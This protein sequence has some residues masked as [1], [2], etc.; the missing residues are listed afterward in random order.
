[1]HDGEVEAGEELSP[2]DL[3]VR[4]VLLGLEVL[5]TDVGGVPGNIPGACAM[6]VSAVGGGNV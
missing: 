2:L 5:K 1:V 6:R 3:S 4:Q